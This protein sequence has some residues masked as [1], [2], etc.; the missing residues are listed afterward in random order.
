MQRRHK[1][2]WA[3]FCLS[4]ATLAAAAVPGI[5]S[6]TN[7]A[8]GNALT[9]GQLKVIALPR[10]LAGTDR[11]A[12]GTYKL[13]N[14]LLHFNQEL[15]AAGG[16]P[17]GVNF[18]Q[19]NPLAKV[20]TAA[21]PQVP[22]VVVDVIV[23]GD[24]NAAA[25]QL[26]SLGFKKTAIFRNDV[27]GLLPVTQI[28]SA[29][30][31]GNV[32]QIHT[33]MMRTRTGAVD[34]QGDFVQKSLALRTN[35]LYKGLNGNALSGSGITV[36]VISDSFDCQ[37]GYAA[38]QATGDLPAGV[39][40]IKDG[41]LYGG[42]TDEGRAMAQIVYDVAPQVTLAFYTAFASEA[43]FAQAI[44][45]LALPTDAPVDPNGLHG[46]GAAIIVD[47]VGY[48]DEPVYQDG[49]VGAAINIVASGSETYTPF[50]S[51]T[52]VTVTFPPVTYFSSA[53]NEGRDSYENTAPQFE[54]AAAA[55]TTATGH[56]TMDGTTELLLNMDTSGATTTNYLPITIPE[57]APGDG[58]VV[59]LEWDQPYFTGT[60]SPT[61]TGT[62]NFLDICLGDASGNPTSDCGGFPPAGPG[63]DPVNGIF[64][65]NGSGST[66]APTQ[67]SLIVGYVSAFGGPLPGRVKIL[68]EDNGRG[69]S[70][71]EFYTA[72]GTIQGHPL[73][74]GGV[75]V[76][77][78]PYYRTPLCGNRPTAELEL[79]SS[80]GGDPFLFD[81]PTGMPLA[82][83]FIPQ[84]PQ[85]VAP[86][87]GS[88]TFFGGALTGI[89]E[90]PPQC[91]QYPNYPHSFAGTSAAAPHAAGVAAL[92]MEAA[93]AA[94]AAV[95]P[96][97]I[98]TAMEKSA[99]DMNQPGFDYD[100]GFGFLQADAATFA[101][102][103]P[104]IKVSSPLIGF[105]VSTDTAA[106]GSVTVTNIGT[107]PL[108][109]SNVVFS[110]ASAALTE[111]D[112]CS[113]APIAAG[114]TCTATVSLAG[115]AAGEYTGSLTFDTNA[116][117]VT[118]PH[119]SVSVVA[120]VNAPASGGGGGG[121]F[122]LITTLM[123][124][125]AAALRRARR[126]RVN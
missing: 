66:T 108:T 13:D 70:I 8:A 49:I 34:S 75:A 114:G 52:P 101:L 30:T 119:Q 86:D 72:S 14:T 85:I 32:R 45:T 19:I 63:F 67:A 105:N 6:A 42:F 90:A 113:A 68:V 28:K 20:V 27:G 57:L 87:R 120:D 99:L 12:D 71:N 81:L 115:S 36:G 44:L 106:T 51:E 3:S 65:F 37:D 117:N 21:T 88:T 31:L 69:N 109:I 48:F 62:A 64:I 77:A 110:S 35:S 56:S 43:D 104:K 82:N 23:K 103:P 96:S 118:S 1:V 122:G 112:N 124:G 10:N 33:A 59:I 102:L 126:Q 74:A 38:D 107:G 95:M 83:S 78:S 26:A 76:G 54:S 17:A 47:D 29:A 100:T 89:Y 39:N 24:P 22:S 9:N 84:K 15:E 46:G 116:A 94:G 123:L 5:A 40:V 41:C 53:G 80:A 98:V 7:A 16:N 50:E 11:L 61:A 125:G 92:M 93:T 60:T 18:K 55:A 121:S 73:A 97:D 111:S 79:F 58:Y 25:A 4:A 2:F 91:Q